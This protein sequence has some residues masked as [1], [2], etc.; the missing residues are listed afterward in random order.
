MPLFRRMNSHRSSLPEREKQ[1]NHHDHDQPHNHLQG[2][3]HFHVIHERIFPAGM[4]RA[5]GG[6]EKG[7]AKHMLVPTETAS[8]SG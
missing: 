7:E 3:A 4:T 2:N 6:V 1:R 5:L 8:S